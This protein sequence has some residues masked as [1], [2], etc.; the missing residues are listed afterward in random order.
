MRAIMITA[1]A[2]NRV[3]AQVAIV[4]AGRRAS[5]HSLHHQMCCWWEKCLLPVD[6]NQ[7]VMQ[8]VWVSQGDST[9]GLTPRRSSRGDAYTS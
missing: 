5:L 9:R 4:A 2:V 6:L 1:A 3:I 7:P 8:P